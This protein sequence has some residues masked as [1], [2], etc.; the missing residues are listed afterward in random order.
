MEK[1][2][3]ELCHSPV[4]GYGVTLEEFKENLE[5]ERKIYESYTESIREL[6]LQEQERL[7]NRIAKLE[8]DVK[9]LKAQLAVCIETIE[10]LQAVK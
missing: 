2:T 8:K 4:Y 3:K 7:K 5:K 1:L 6:K 9:D 10:V